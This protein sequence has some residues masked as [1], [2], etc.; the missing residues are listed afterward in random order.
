MLGTLDLLDLIARLST[1]ISVIIA[2]LTAIWGI[3][4][5]RREHVGRRRV[6]LAEEVLAL[7]YEASDVIGYIRS[8]YASAGEGSTRKREP[9]EPERSK[10]AMDRAHVPMERYLEH[11][12]LFSRIRALRY[13][14][15]THFGN[16][17][18]APFNELRDVINRIMSA[19][20]GLKRHAIGRSPEEYAD[21]NRREKAR[22]RQEDYEQVIWERPGD[23]IRVEVDKIVEQVESTC[24][25]AIGK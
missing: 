5:W 13:R 21:R 15:R 8:P 25:N 18:T 10:H 4:S 9:N 6:D 11:D 23:S 1:P 24:R 2:A 22:K 12:E 17:S 19:S 20:N 7:F 14:F 16:E 3:T